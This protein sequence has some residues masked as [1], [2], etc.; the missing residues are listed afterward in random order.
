M[1][2]KALQTRLHRTLLPLLFVSSFLVVSPQFKMEPCGCPNTNEKSRAAIENEPGTSNPAVVYINRILQ[3]S[4]SSC[5]S[6]DT[7]FKVPE[8]LRSVNPEAYTPT[9]ISIGPFHSDRKDLKANLLKPMYLRHLFNLSHLS[10]NTIVETVQT[11]EQ[12]V[13]CCYTESIEMNRDE[14]VKLLVLDACFVVMHLISWQNPKLDIPNAA[15]LWQSWYEIFVDLMLLENQLPFFLLQSLYDLFAPSQ[16]LLEHKSFIQIV[17][18]YFS[19]H[20]NSELILIDIESSAENVN[21]FVDLVRMR[22]TDM[23]FNRTIIQGLVWPP[24]ATELHECGVIFSTGID[25]KF[26]DQS[27]CLQLLPINI[28]NT[29]EKRVKNI[30]AYEQHHIHMNIWNEVSNFALFMTSLVQTDQ[31]VKLLI[32]GGIIQNELGSIKDVTQLFYNLGKYIN[33]GFNSYNSD[34]QKMKD[35][36]KRRRHRWMTSLRRNYFSTPW[37]CASTIAAILLLALTLIQTIVA[38]LTGFKKSS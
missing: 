20:N 37:L 26:N 16:P 9:V 32:E 1:L 29:F 3:Q 12:R 18:D 27:G 7:I 24:S 8:P 25:I 4:V 2:V 36:C 30:I 17:Q 22:K 23:V 14:F 34:C 38:V 35:Y 33:I 31:D 5:F 19:G 15:Y 6:D 11:L 13:R 21:H 28:D 10:V